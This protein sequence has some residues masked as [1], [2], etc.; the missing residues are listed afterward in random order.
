MSV[1]ADLPDG[2]TVIGGAPP[3]PEART[4]LL[5]VARNEALRLP[6]MLDWHIGL[7]VDHVILLDNGSTDGTPE[8]ALR[9]GDR[10]LVL[11]VAG[12]F[13]QARQDEWRMAVLDRLCADRWV[14]P[15]DADELLVYPGMEQA[16]IGAFCTHLESIGAAC[17]TGFMLDMYGDAPLGRT[18][19]RA[20]APLLESFPFH[21]ATPPRRQRAADFPHCEQYGGVRA[22]VFFPEADPG[23]PARFLHQRL[24]NVA[25]RLNPWRDAGWF[26]RLAPRMPPNLTKVP[27]I[28]WQPG[29]MMISSVHRTSPLAR[30]DHQPGVVLLHFKFLRDFHERAIDAVRRGI[31]HDNSSEYARYLA[32]LRAGEQSLMGPS[33]VRWRD[34]QHLVTLG[35]MEDT[36][37]WRSARRE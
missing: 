12:T 20:G 32:V 31:H 3:G 6:A 7:G 14:I 13:S 30:A 10:A 19:Y 33:S 29:T 26:R 37:A 1:V 22:R 11:A 15:A 35:L 21:D 9:L 17:A 36:P 27:L 25:H 28:R 5:V 4:V 34:S 23:R 24:F 8:L 18:A 16:A 2:M